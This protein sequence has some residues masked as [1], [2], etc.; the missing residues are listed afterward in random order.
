[1]R[2]VWVITTNSGGHVYNIVDGKFRYCKYSSQAAAN[3]DIKRFVH[4]KNYKAEQVDRSDL[5]R[6]EKIIR[7]A[8]RRG[9][10]VA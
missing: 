3:R 5:V 10:N 2:K 1:M 8:R 6:E 9:L 4:Q 7:R